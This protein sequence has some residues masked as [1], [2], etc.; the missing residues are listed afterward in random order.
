MRIPILAVVAVACVVAA[1]V[2]GRSA[3]RLQRVARRVEGEFGARPTPRS[4]P[5]P[6]PQGRP[7]DGALLRHRRR[8]RRRRHPRQPGHRV[9]TLVLIPVVIS[10]IFS[11]NF[12]KEARLEQNRTELERRAQ[13]VL[14]QDELA[15]APLGRPAGPRRPARHRRVRARPGL[16]GRHRADGRRLLRRRSRRPDRIAA[17]IGDVTGHGIDPSITAFQA[18]YLLRVF[19]RQYRDPAQ[20]LEELNAQMSAIGRPEEFISLCVVVFDT[21]AG[22]LRLRVGRA[23][24]GVAVARPRRQPAAAD[25]PA[26]DA[27]PARPAT[28]PG[29]SRSTPNDLCS[30]TP[31]GW[32][33]PATASQLFG[34]ERI[35]NT[36]APRPR[37][38]RPTCCAR[39]CSRRPATSPPGRSPTTSPSWPIRR[40]L[41]SSRRRRHG[42][43]R[44]GAARRPRPGRGNLDKGADKLAA[45]HKLFVRDRIDLLRRPRL[46]RRG[47]P[48][49]Q[50]PR[51][52][53]CPPTAWS[54]A[55]GAVDGR[56][57]C[58]MANDPTV[59]AGSWGARTVEKIVRLTE[60]ALRDELPGVLAGRLGRGAHHR[61]GRAVPRPPRRR[62]DLLQPGAAVRAGAAGL[63]PV[64]AVG[65][66]RCVHPERSATS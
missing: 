5:G 55:S 18:K 8:P 59:K 33:R 7:H 62:A 23:P 38:G 50:R 51:P 22:T 17:V 6:R 29:R 54:P 20:A 43:A 44:A 31:T 52:T 57:V 39:R 56:P 60:H 36:S 1:G 48:A 41:S 63:L 4:S 32:P 28:T 14:V 65:G 16:P 42:P 53:T 10:M 45:Q 26:A 30:S 47:R 24:G 37:R 46:V 12:V 35:A 64:R 3:R 27:R 13:E 61:P 66:R 49:G 21:E 58:V 19:L 15:P 34:E 9:F 2:W 40:S 11:R 25:R